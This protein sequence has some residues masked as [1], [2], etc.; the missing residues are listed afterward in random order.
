MINIISSYNKLWQI[1]TNY[2]NLY[3]TYIYKIYK[4]IDRIHKRYTVHDDPI[5]PF[6]GDSCRLGP[7]YKQLQGQPK[8]AYMQ[9][10]VLWKLRSRAI[11]HRHHCEHYH[12]CMWNAMFSFHNF[13]CFEGLN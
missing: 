10:C 2:N 13:V 11:S 4:H 1:I 9:L 6:E 7:A 3:T 8:T 12:A 5:V